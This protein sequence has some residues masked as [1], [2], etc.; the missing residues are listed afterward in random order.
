MCLQES[1]QDS[2]HA[3]AATRKRPAVALRTSSTARRRTAWRRRVAPRKACSCACSG[4]GVLAA[5]GGTRSLASN[6]AAGQPSCWARCLG[7]LDGRGAATALVASRG[8]LASE[9][10]RPFAWEGACKSFGVSVGPALCRPWGPAGVRQL[11]AWSLGAGSSA[12]PS[13]LA[14]GLA[15]SALLRF[16][17][18][19]RAWGVAGESAREHILRMCSGPELAGAFPVCRRNAWWRPGLL[20]VGAMRPEALRKLALRSGIAELDLHLSVDLELRGCRVMLRYA[21]ENGRCESIEGQQQDALRASCRQEG[22]I[23]VRFEPAGQTHELVS[24]TAGGHAGVWHRLDGQ[25]LTRLSAALLPA[26]E[27]MPVPFGRNGTATDAGRALVAKATASSGAPAGNIA[28]V[29]R[30]LWCALGGPLVAVAAPDPAGSGA[31]GSNT[32]PASLLLE[33]V[34]LEAMAG[35]AAT[36][37]AEG[38]TDMG[39]GLR[40]AQRHALAAAGA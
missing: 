35:V 26:A 12:L 10:A 3:G 28:A 34:L 9:R 19:D 21:F 20:K 25:G 6:L 40:A 2:G 11:A 15:A 8:S 23:R 29:L 14:A 27:P 4:P 18:P 17:L 39:G 5:E 36:P 22:S 16:G 30:F 33:R 37:G 7:F 24:W 13:H 32:A 31:H 38:P 1:P